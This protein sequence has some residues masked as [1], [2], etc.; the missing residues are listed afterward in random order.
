MPCRLILSLLLIGAM[1]LC[2]GCFGAR[3]TEDVAYI[4]TIGVDKDVD[5]QEIVTYQIAVPRGGGGEDSMGGK[6]EEA[7]NWI[8][9]T[10]TAPNPSEARMLLKSTMSRY[11]NISHISAII[12]GEQVAR[13]GIG[14]LLSY[15]MRNRD[16]RE[17]ILIVVVEG[18]AEDYIRRN[19]P[20]LEKNVAKYYET[21]FQDVESGYYV[22]ADLHDFY[23]ALK[24][25]GISP[26]AV[27]SANNAKRGENQPAAPPSPQ[28]GTE[29]YLAGGIPRAGTAN[30]TE[31]FGLALFR[32][33]KMT[34]V[35]DSEET[36]AVNLLRGKG[37]R[38]YVGVVDPLD[39]KYF[40]NMAVRLG[41]K[42][43]IKGEL[44]DNGPIFDVNVFIEAEIM[45]IPSGINYELGENRAVLEQQL[46]ALFTE[47]MTRMIEHTQ[48]LGC[49]P[50]G[51]GMYLRPKFADYNAVRQADFAALYQAAEIH[52][53][54]NSKIRRTGLDWQTTQNTAKTGEA[55]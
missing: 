24:S 19:K 23:I 1:L 48:Q 36:R 18:T 43:K 32:G 11:P 34:G 42:P 3:E 37:V 52:V 15:F 46:S 29:S 13:E 27:Y 53:N 47:Q 55:E 14:E 6:G 39:P 26:V 33:D 31:F 38:A 35:L 17:T 22:R 7:G 50:V 28:Q 40:V 51:F 25:G 2:S 4:L 16:F 45:G 41:A 54:V 10:I 9:N 44:R 20:K 30:T 49:D 5:G 21:F 8:T 12:L